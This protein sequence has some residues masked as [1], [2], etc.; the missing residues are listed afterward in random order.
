MWNKIL[1]TAATTLAVLGGVLFATPASANVPPPEGGGSWDHIWY[2]DDVDDRNGQHFWVLYGEENGD[3][4]R[5]CDTDADGEYASARIAWEFADDEHA[6]TLAIGGEGNC[7][8]SDYHTH[9][10]TEGVTVDIQVSMCAKYCEEYVQ[11]TWYK[12][13]H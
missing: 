9:D 3:E 11:D 7:V 1:G 12:N 4:F 8:E 13:D 2:S 5:L 10:I 6:F